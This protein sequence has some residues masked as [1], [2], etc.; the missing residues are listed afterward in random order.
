MQQGLARIYQIIAWLITVGVLL[1][2]FLAGLGVFGA[3]DF[4]PHVMLGLLLSL[5]SL[6]LLILAAAGRLGG[7]AIKFAAVLFGLMIVQ[8]LLVRLGAISRVISA[9]HPVNAVAILFV[10][11]EVAR[12]RPQAVGSPTSADTATAATEAGR[13]TDVPADTAP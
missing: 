12:R 9:L 11:H 6:I 13:A 7:S 3:M 1:Q 10:A 4:G 5:L 2:F 8:M